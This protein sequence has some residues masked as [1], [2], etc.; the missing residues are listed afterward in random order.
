MNQAQR[1]AFNAVL[2]ALIQADRTIDT[3]EVAA[4]MAD[5]YHVR[6]TAQEV[7]AEWYRQLARERERHDRHS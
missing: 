4:L 1:A 7:A 3:R 6:A 5:L 2:S